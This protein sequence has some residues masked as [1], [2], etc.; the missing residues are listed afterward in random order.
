MVKRPSETAAGV[1][2]VRVHC[3]GSRAF[4]VHFTFY[5][6]GGL[7]DECVSGGGGG[8]GGGGQQFWLRLSVRQP[9][10]SSG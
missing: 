2:S 10:W 7:L 4:L 3:Q 8:G 1:T 5:V 9:W 6:L